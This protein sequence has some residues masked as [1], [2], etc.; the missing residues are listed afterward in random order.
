VR[1]IRPM[2][3]DLEVEVDFDSVGIRTFF[4]SMAK[5]KLV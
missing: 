1:A 5:L 3:F 2:A 4:G